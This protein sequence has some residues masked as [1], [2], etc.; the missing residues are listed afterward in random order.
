ML[1][2]FR[3]KDRE[4]IYFFALCAAV[5]IRGLL[6]NETLLV[7]ALPNLPFWLGSKIVTLT[8]PACV[9]LMMY[10]TR[11]IYRADMPGAVFNVLLTVHA[12]YALLVLAASSYFYS[13][14]FIYYLYAVEASCALGIYVS[15]R[16]VLKKRRE[17][18]YFMSGMLFFIAGAAVDILRFG[19][20]VGI[21]YILS[22][23]LTAF[24]A[25]QSVLLAKRHS[26]AIAMSS[27]CLTICGP[28]WIKS[29]TRRPRF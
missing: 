15:V 20:H 19:Q 7:Q 12:L 10:Y 22:A 8:I 6:S 27:C 26:D 11:T 2:L 29:R 28:R 16:V 14:V 18:V 23:G 13:L 3:K 5:C 4:L 17:S 9:V 24:V 1:Y 25:A 21:G